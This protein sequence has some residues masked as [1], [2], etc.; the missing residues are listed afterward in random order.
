MAEQIRSGYLPAF[1]Q[2]SCVSVSW[3][4]YCWVLLCDETLFQYTFSS[5]KRKECWPMKLQKCYSAEC[6]MNYIMLVGY[7]LFE[8]RFH[9]GPSEPNYLTSTCL[10]GLIFCLYRAMGDHRLN[11]WGPIQWGP[12]YGD[13]DAISSSPIF[14][15]TTPIVFIVGCEGF[16]VYVIKWVKCITIQCITRLVQNRLHW[17]VEWGFLSKTDMA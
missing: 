13:Y 8:L 11:F 15:E 9:K 12:I 14:M 10:M 16:R 3:C 2:C 1:R 17:N 7:L 5:L 6:R 4:P